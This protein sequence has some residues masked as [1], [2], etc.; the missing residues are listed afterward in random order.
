[1]S[2]PGYGI[3]LVRNSAVQRHAGRCNCK[4]PVGDIFNVLWYNVSQLAKSTNP[5]RTSQRTFKKCLRRP[6]DGRWTPLVFESANS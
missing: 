2:L 3:K 1:M 6:A 5:E 4:L